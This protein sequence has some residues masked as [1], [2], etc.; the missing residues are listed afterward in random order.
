MSNTIEIGGTDTEIKTSLKEI[1][2]K[3]HK[4]NKRVVIEE[5]EVVDESSHDPE[6]QETYM[7]ILNELTTKHVL[8]GSAPF[9]VQN[10][11]YYILYGDSDSKEPT[12]L[13]KPDVLDHFSKL[14]KV[15]EL[16]L[17]NAGFN[18]IVYINFKTAFSTRDKSKFK[19]KNDDGG[20]EL[21]PSSIRTFK[22]Q[23]DGERFREKL[24]QI[25]REL[26][27][28]CQDNDLLDM[29]DKIEALF[30]KNKPTGKKGDSLKKS[31]EQYDG[32]HDDE[33]K[34]SI[35]EKVSDCAT[36]QEALKKYGR[37]AT[38]NGIV[39]MWNQRVIKTPEKTKYEEELSNPKTHLKYRYHQELW[40]MLTAPK[41]DDR[42]LCW[43]V[44]PEGGKE[45]SKFCKVFT[46]VYGGIILKTASG[47]KDIARLLQQQIESGAKLNYILID[48]PRAAVHHKM[49][50]TIECMLD[51]IFTSLKYEG[52]PLV[53]K[54]LP[55]I[56]VFSNED[57]PFHP[58]LDKVRTQNEGKPKF[59]RAPKGSKQKYLTEEGF[60]CGISDDRWRIFDLVEGKKMYQVEK[61]D[62]VVVG[63]KKS[64]WLS[65]RANPFFDP[66]FDQKKPED[67][68]L[69]FRMPGDKPTK[70][71]ASM[72]NFIKD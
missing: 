43:I 35:F 28:E 71:I 14:G 39:I 61:D 25:N 50:D 53:L 37:L 69:V 5:K 60:S 27:S 3:A 31:R 72:G 11:L 22:T 49:W 68:D 29:S 67:P 65:E 13:D 40:D 41:W 30:K 36:L 34:R 59:F 63:F 4:E 66:Y 32:E 20:G 57:P 70:T 15:E 21:S 1:L 23:K 8:D 19:L 38:A 56:M 54:D 26:V 48:L 6:D 2:T 52:K 17:L 18:S 62:K 16:Y 64:I 44:D 10:R 46:Q 47:A 24:M 33:D 7:D 55:R 42:R 9:R 45:K 12:I 51:G 58:V